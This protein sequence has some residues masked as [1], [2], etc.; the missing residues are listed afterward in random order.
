M[1]ISD[2]LIANPSGITAAIAMWIISISIL[3]LVLEK[4]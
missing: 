3:A 1:H 2:G 4:S